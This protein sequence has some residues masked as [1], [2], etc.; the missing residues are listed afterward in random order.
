MFHVQLEAPNLSLI[1][2]YKSELPSYVF[3]FLS[4]WMIVSEKVSLSPNQCMLISSTVAL[5]TFL[6]DNN[7]KIN[8]I[9]INK[10]QVFSIKYI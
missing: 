6:K 8:S 9:N 1:Q 7:R 2:I 5:V 4:R 3:P 10:Q